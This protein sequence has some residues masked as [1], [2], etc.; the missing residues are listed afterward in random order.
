MFA[1]ARWLIPRDRV[2]QLFISGRISGVYKQKK[3]Y[4]ESWRTGMDTFV[5]IMQEIA[6]PF[7]AFERATTIRA[8][9]RMLKLDGQGNQTTNIRHLVI[10]NAVVGLTCRQGADGTGGEKF[11]DAVMRGHRQDLAHVQ[12]IRQMVIA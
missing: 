5:S 4:H 7:G 2:L 8:Y 3:T 1:F 11:R 12:T 6:P 9:R 10:K